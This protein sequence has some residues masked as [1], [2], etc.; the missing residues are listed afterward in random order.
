[1]SPEEDEPAHRRSDSLGQASPRDDSD[2][3]DT[4]RQTEASTDPRGREKTSPTRPDLQNVDSA[5][6]L[7]KPALPALTTYSLLIFATIWGVLAR[8]GLEWIGG[9]AER[10]V[11]AVLW[12]QIVGCVVMGFVTERKGEIES[13]Y[14]PMFTMLGTGFCGSLTTWS[15]MANDTFFAFANFDQPRGTS[16]FAGFLSG[17]AVTLVTLVASTCSLRFGVHL[18]SFL[19]S[20]PTI[21]APS[22]PNRSAPLINLLALSIG[23][24]FFLGSLFL[25]IFGPSRYRIRATFAIVLGPPGTILRYLL[26]QH[27]NSRSPR[28]PFGTFLANTFAVLVFAVVGLLARRPAD[29]T[30]SCAALKGMQDGFCAS[31]STVSTLV[32][33]LRKL[34][35]RD[36]YRYFGASWIVSELFMVVVL[37]SWVWSGDR[38]ALCWS[39]STSVGGPA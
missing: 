13:I 1:M 23:P 20:F 24:L 33:E 27:L 25:L 28:F 16:R 7:I 18:S 12:A 2:D 19:P 26:S 6:P 31:L 36:S 39:P 30:L 3:S 9:F 14:P 4:T 15:T 32:V 35:R 29:S 17:V 21:R 22:R 11:F 38:G 37:G 34:G 5:H 10:E 8:L